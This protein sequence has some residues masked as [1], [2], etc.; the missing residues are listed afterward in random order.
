MKRLCLL[1]E[2][3][4]LLYTEAWVWQQQ[5]QQKK[6]REPEHPDVLFLLEHA[7]VYTLGQGSS[8]DFVKFAP[9]TFALHRTER[10]GEVTYHGPG[11][12]VG[13]PILD[14]SYYQK[15]LHW[16]LRQL[17]EVIIR[18]L[19]PLDLVGERV[20]GMTGVWVQDHK[21]A[22]IGIK[23]SR[24]VTL[25]GFALNV[26]TDLAAFEVI[27]P[28][29]LTKPVGS[30]ELFCPGITLIETQKLVSAAFAEVFEVELMRAVFS[31]L[32]T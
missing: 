30:L 17:E 10:G 26:T 11:Q 12:L 31:P 18:A 2:P 15:D 7:A 4:L 22:A 28:C 29:G 23:V 3:G 1:Y 8:L 20:S 13:Y 5:I 19:K 32:E 27:V 14:L 9:G 16:Y 25:H 24:W 21:I 6:I